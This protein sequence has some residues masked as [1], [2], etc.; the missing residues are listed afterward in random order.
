MSDPIPEGLTF[1]SEG[2]PNGYAL[3]AGDLPSG[4]TNIGV[5]CTADPTSTQT[6]TTYCYYEGPTA[7]YPQGRVVWQGV[8]GPDQGASDAEQAHNEINVTFATEARLG[9]KRVKNIATLD[10]DL[11]GDEVISASELG[12]VAASEQWEADRLPDTGFLPGLVTRIPEQPSEKAYTATNMTLEI[13]KLDISAPVTTI[14]FED[15]T[16]DVTWLGNQVGYLEGSAFPTWTG[17]TVLTAHVTTPYDT[18]GLFADLSSLVYGDQILI[19][20]YGR[21]YTY[22][23]RSRRIVNNTNFDATFK[24]ERLDWVTLMT[25]TGFDAD[26]GEYAYRQLVRAVLVDID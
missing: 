7:S 22:E 20:A 1:I 24:Q 21:T 4:T 8:L 6:S 3:P 12:I 5:K 9:L 17:N 26:N 10:V 13:P 14:P 15:G 18:P 11:N 19:H 2:D 23:M 25:C 16:W